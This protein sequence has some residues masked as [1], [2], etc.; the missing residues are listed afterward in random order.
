MILDFFEWLPRLPISFEASLILSVL[1]VSLAVA[2]LALI[3]NRRLLM[4]T[5]DGD[6]DLGTIFESPASILPHVIELRVRLVN[7][8]IAIG[9][10]TIVA[11]MLSESILDVI[12]EPVGGVD[13]LQAIGVTEPFGVF[14]RIALTL[15]IILAAPFVISQIWI[16]IAAGL[17]PSER[18][19]FYLF[20]PFAVILFLFGVSF[21]YAVMLPV[22][23]P[24]LVTFMG[25]NATP[26]LDNYV[27]FVTTVLLW[28]GISFEMPLITFVLA[29]LGIVNA[30][31]LARN[32]RIAIV[33]IA[34]LSA[35]I[36]PTPDPVNMGIM[37][38]PLFGL[39]LLSIV[40]AV[41]A[42][43]GRK[44]DEEESS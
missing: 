25:V 14:F 6:A 4:G 30:G 2:L 20:V 32:W 21:A 9:V 27:K 12:A 34:I 43:R 29:R 26:T 31:M 22:A 39:Y 15:G 44:L 41:F 33:L 7:S 3:R 17:K 24:F 36:T 35:L 13:Q 40:L 10:G 38:A 37:A 1:V 23:V 8:L 19:A 5:E 16:F 18:R 28:V 42:Q 11:T